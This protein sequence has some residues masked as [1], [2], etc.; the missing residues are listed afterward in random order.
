VSCSSH[1]CTQLAAFFIDP[2]AEQ[3]LG[4]MLDF[5]LQVSKKLKTLRRLLLGGISRKPARILSEVLS[6][7][8]E[9][10]YPLTTEPDGWDAEVT[11]KGTKQTKVELWGNTRWR[12]PEFA[13]KLL[14]NDE[15]LQRWT[16]IKAT[17]GIGLHPAALWEVI[18]WSWM[19]DWFAHIQ[20]ILEV[21][22]YRPLAVDFGGGNVC[23]RR[24]TKG[25]LR[26]DPY[27][28]VPDRHLSEQVGFHFERCT[29]RRDVFEQTLS[30]VSVPGLGIGISPYQVSIL[31]A[32][33]ATKRKLSSF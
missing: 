33:V 25:D 20:T 13:A 2:R 5:G 16:A 3:D 10:T 26:L 11:W 1:D 17:Y 18:P 22:Y 14:R 32:L 23:T 27:D 4:K 12:M 19:V 31:A 21:S 15:D 29:K 24:T 30:V 9:F 6:A 28:Q 8:I 7:D